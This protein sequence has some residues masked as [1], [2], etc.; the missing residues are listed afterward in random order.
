MHIPAPWAPIWPR[1][2]M[3]AEHFCHLLI[4]SVMF[5]PQFLPGFSLLTPSHPISALTNK[6]AEIKQVVFFPLFCPP[7]VEIAQQR[8]L[9]LLASRLSHCRVSRT[10]RWLTNNPCFPRVANQAAESLFLAS[11]SFSFVFS[12]WE[13]WHGSLVRPRCCS[14]MRLI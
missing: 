11:N 7:E 3:T 14:L 8:T 9:E 13:S 10:D 2:Q 6:G 1:A 4:Y 12:P 5:S